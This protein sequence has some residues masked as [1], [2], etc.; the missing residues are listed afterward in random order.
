MYKFIKMNCLHNCMYRSTMMMII[1]GSII[2]MSILFI[3][4]KIYKMILKIY[5]N[6]KKKLPIYQNMINKKQRER[7]NS[8]F[9]IMNKIYIPIIFV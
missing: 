5:N 9:K 2:D 1:N 8:I 7:L 6:R 3:Q 4:P